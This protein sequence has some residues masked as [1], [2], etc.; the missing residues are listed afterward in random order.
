MRTE[1]PTQKD[2]YTQTEVLDTEMKQRSAVYEKVDN[3]R[4]CELIRIVS[5]LHMERCSTD[6]EQN[7][8]STA[9]FL[10]L[11]LNLCSFK[12]KKEP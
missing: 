5:S 3:A 12:M 8:A 9:S 10:E 1:F 11:S 4:R 2:Q 6:H 7:R